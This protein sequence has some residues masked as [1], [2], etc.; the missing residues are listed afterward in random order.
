MTELN[1][2]RDEDAPETVSTVWDSYA[3][4]TSSPWGQV[5]SAVELAPGIWQVT[6]PSHGGIWLSDERMELM[7]KAMWNTAYSK[8]PW[9]EEDVDWALVCAIYPDAFDDRTHTFATRTLKWSAGR[10]TRSAGSQSHQESW[11]MMRQWN[12]DLNG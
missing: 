9:F 1:I 6:T 8:A 12:A 7:P 3:R 5:E 2:D 4:P 10:G 11:D